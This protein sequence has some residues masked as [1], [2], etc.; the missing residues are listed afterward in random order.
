MATSQ[1]PYDWEQQTDE[2]PASAGAVAPD[3]EALASADLAE[4][5]RVMDLYV[6]HELAL[7]LGVPP[8]AIDTTGRPMGSLGVGSI[9]GLVLQSRM[10]A[11]LRVEVNLQRLLLANSAAELIDCLAKQLGAPASGAPA[12]SAAESAA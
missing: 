3:L 6:R 10:E 5:T 8:D 2:A 12:P 4:R 11:A 1:N 9:S 7:V